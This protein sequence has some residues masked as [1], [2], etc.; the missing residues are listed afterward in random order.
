MSR[1][2]RAP[3]AACIRQLFPLA[4]IQPDCLRGLRREAGRIASLF[5]DV[6]DAFLSMGSQMMKAAARFMT[7]GPKAA[8]E[9]KSEP[10]KEQPV[11][12]KKAS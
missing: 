4:S 11:H 7:N 8:D 1:R 10:K 12:Q 2:W 5:P 6:T 9:I 3:G